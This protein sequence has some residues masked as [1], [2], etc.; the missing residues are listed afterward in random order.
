MTLY[1]SQNI[2]TALLHLKEDRIL[3]QK[4]ERKKML[5]LSVLQLIYKVFKRAA[6]NFVKKKKI[7][8]NL[9]SRIITG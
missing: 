8:K 7:M 6:C 9:K 2:P 4:K 5:L 1:T 3:R